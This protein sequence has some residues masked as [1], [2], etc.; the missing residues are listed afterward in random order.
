MALPSKHE[1]PS[2]MP[3]FIKSH[4]NLDI[5]IMQLNVRGQTPMQ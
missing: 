1:F 5:K 4:I 2:L 3:N